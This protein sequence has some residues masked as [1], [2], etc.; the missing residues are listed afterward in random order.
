[1][2]T[3]SPQTWVF[4]V[5]AG[6]V[7]RLEEDYKKIAKAVR[8]P[9]WD[10]KDAD[11]LGIVCEWLS[12]ESNGPWV[13]ILDNADSLDV[14]T[15]P[16]PA[17][18]ASKSDSSAGAQQIIDFLPHSPK[19]SILITTRNR[20]VASRLV[21][22]HKRILRVEPMDETEGVALLKSKLDAPHREDEMRT[23]VRALDYMPLAISQA[24]AYISNKSPRVT[25]SSYLRELKTSNEE[26]T[27]LLD[28]NM[29]ESHRERERSNSIVATWQV[30]FQYVRQTKPSA[31]RLLS[32]MCLFDRQGIPEA[33]LTAQ[34]GEEVTKSSQ[35]RKP[36]WKRRRRVRRSKRH[37]PEGHVP[38]P[39]F[40][41]DWITLT[42]FS[43]IKTNIDG[44]HFSMHALVQFTTKKWLSVHGELQVWSR[45]Y[46]TVLNAYFPDPHGGLFASCEPLVAHA[47][48][49]IPYRPAATAGEVLQA[50]ARLVT[51]LAS[52]T[53]Q[54]AAI[55]TAE[56][57]YRAAVKA[58]EDTLGPNA[59]ETLACL[60]EHGVMLF[61]CDKLDEAEKVQRRV[62]E[63]RRKS[64]G[65]EHND[66]L[67][68]MDYLSNLLTFQRNYQEAEALQVRAVDVRLRT[69]G[70]SH[71][72]TL[73]ALEKR[74]IFLMGRGR[75]TES[76]ETFR[77]AHDARSQGNE[78]QL[79][80]SW[81][82]DLDLLGLKLFISNRFAEAEPLLREAVTAKENMLGYDHWR[83]MKSVVPLARALHAQD[84]HAEAETFYRRGFT[85]YMEQEGDEH[86]ETLK[87]INELA[88]VLASQDK[89]EEAEKLNRKSL[90][91]RETVLGPA[92]MDTLESAFTLAGILEKQARFEEALLLYERAY[93]GAMESAGESHEDT[94][95]FGREYERLQQEMTAPLEVNLPSS[96]KG[97]II[98][99]PSPDRETSLDP[100][101]PERQ[102]LAICSS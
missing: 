68:T 63:G 91:K 26:S 83:T 100:R 41:E 37:K 10:E 77:Q 9:G 98:S 16:P 70:K 59:P 71:K 97:I 80:P 4:W 24:A 43:F 89:L 84:K 40:D 33:L 79:D 38:V 18:A 102:R 101:K 58:F 45:K 19:G 65:P 22:N 56:K 55:D 61:H 3:K 75:Y 51:K 29:T 86:E 39:D 85:W 25:I 47:Y 94:K 74:G 82:S 54:R 14:L 72:S 90:G 62:L 52:Y 50:W 27:G 17:H 95:E 60:Y 44:H 23:L 30:S 53:D 73:E 5:H 64:L 12:K 13:I 32:L 35:P 99:A 46:I 1:M 93:N 15:A 76:Y 8:I 36:W 21:G 48:A 67:E 96:P 57:F 87:V 49:A 78:E 7:A 6:S 69:L 81:T 31:A 42:D 11:I 34:Y 66:T 28:E 88:S 20:E 2:H 92:H